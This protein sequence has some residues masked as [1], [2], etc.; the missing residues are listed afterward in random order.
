ML[1]VLVLFSLALKSSHG[2]IN[3]NCNVKA[4]LFKYQRIIN[5]Q[6][7]SSWSSSST[8]GLCE[9][10]RTPLNK[11][12]NKD[13]SAIRRQKRTK[14]GAT[15]TPTSIIGNVLPALT[16]SML[17]SY[18]GNVP[19][20]QAFALNAFLFTILRTKLLKMLTREG[21]LHSLF[22]GTVLWTTLGWR[23][24]TTCVVYLFL[25]SVSTC[26]SCHYNI[27]SS[28][29]YGMMIGSIFYCF[30]LF[31]IFLFILLTSP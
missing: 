21:F 13:L 4:K 3:S 10:Y 1:L 23:G 2:F 25:G 6:E 9:G 29:S 11:S 24:W 19:L 27:I 8:I 12:N 17:F 31:F 16:K 20:S 28:S 30:F 22:L 7:L 26:S 14:L 15:T 5:D 18:Q